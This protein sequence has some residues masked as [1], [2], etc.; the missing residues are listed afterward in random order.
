MENN[1]KYLFFSTNTNWNKSSSFVSS[2]QHIFSTFDSRNIPLRFSII[3]R[4]FANTSTFNFY[5]N[6]TPKQTLNSF[7]LV[8]F[9]SSP[10]VQTSKS[11]ILTSPK[12]KGFNMRDE[13]NLNNFPKSPM[14]TSH[15]PNIK[16]N[17]PSIMTKTNKNEED[18]QRR[19]K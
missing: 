12:E 5:H 14:A 10:P 9:N 8:G 13:E 18:L 7:L 15:H 4:F 16:R 11:K 6:I 2:H 3:E 19:I 17:S 1:K